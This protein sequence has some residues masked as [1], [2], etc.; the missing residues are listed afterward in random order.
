MWIVWFVALR[1]I[2]YLLNRSYSVSQQFFTLID[3]LENSCGFSM[4]NHIYFCTNSY[5]NELT[6]LSLFTKGPDLTITQ[7]K[8]RLASY[9]HHTFHF[10]KRGLK[11]RQDS[12]THLTMSMWPAIIL[13]HTHVAFGWIRS[14]EGS[15]IFPPITITIISFFKT[16]RT[17]NPSAR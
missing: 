8:V 13:S 6:I 3:V 12:S 1:D 17:P 2:D 4:C 7:I 5:S 11:I 15:K 14:L 10:V 16:T 9:K